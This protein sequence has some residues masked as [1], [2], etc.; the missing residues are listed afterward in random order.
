[1]RDGT[2]PGGPAGPTPPQPDPGPTGPGRSL[3]IRFPRGYA[4]RVNPGRWLVFYRRRGRDY[5]T[6]VT[7]RRAARRLLQRFAI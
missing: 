1:M 3:V 5:A 7:R 4:L 6:V 2:G